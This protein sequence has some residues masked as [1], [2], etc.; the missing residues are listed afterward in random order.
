MVAAGAGRAPPP[1]AF[2]PG[3]AHL[4]HASLRNPSRPALSRARVSGYM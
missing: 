1:L 2:L 4:R 3:A